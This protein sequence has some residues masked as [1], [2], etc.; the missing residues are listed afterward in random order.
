MDT[1][2]L[3]V[4]EWLDKY[5]V[6]CCDEDVVEYL[7]EGV[8]EFLDNNNKDYFDAYFIYAYPL[9]YLLE[10][11]LGGKCLFHHDYMHKILWSDTYSHFCYHHNYKKQMIYHDHL[12]GGREKG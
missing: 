2:K 7:D 6:A 9:E 12:N 8:L 1:N 3:F 10:E 5:E 4:V 11:T